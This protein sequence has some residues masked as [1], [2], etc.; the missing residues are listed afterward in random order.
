MRPWQKA[1]LEQLTGNV[2]FKT[3]NT[4]LLIGG[5]HTKHQIEPYSVTRERGAY[6]V[7][8]KRMVIPSPIMD[9]LM[10]TEPLEF[11]LTGEG[12]D[13]IEGEC[14]LQACVEGASSEHYRALE[15]VLFLIQPK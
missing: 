1:Y 7:K 6:Y 9:A 13:R 14:Y 12:D 10:N 2:S 4:E 3:K 5:V 15:D 8:F 11:K